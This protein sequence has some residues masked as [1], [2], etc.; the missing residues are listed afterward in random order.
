MWFEQTLDAASAS[1][2]CS[3]PIKRGVQSSNKTLPT[4]SHPLDTPEPRLPKQ[5]AFRSNSTHSF[6]GELP[7]RVAIRI[8]NGS[9]TSAVAF[10]AAKHCSRQTLNQKLRWMSLGH[11]STDTSHFDTAL[12]KKSVSLSCS[13]VTFQTISPVRL[14]MST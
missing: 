7:W 11:H 14:F 10:P 2:R 13:Q 12:V 6:R 9:M 8:Y 3:G 5:S 1:P 4:C